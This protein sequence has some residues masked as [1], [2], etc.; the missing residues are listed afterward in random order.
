MCPIGYILVD[1]ITAKVQATL[2]NNPLEEAAKVGLKVWPVLM[3]L[4]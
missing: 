3:E 4:L 1:K 2:V